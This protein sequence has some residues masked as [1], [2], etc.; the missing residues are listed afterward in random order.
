MTECPKCRKDKKSD[1][2]DKK[3]QKNKHDHH[4]EHSQIDHI[5][6]KDKK[7]IIKTNK[8]CDCKKCQ[9][10]KDSKAIKPHNEDKH[11]AKKTE[12]KNEVCKTNF[13]LAHSADKMAD[14]LP[15]VKNAN[16]SRSVDIDIDINP[17]VFTKQIENHNR[18]S[19]EIELDARATPNCRVVEK[20]V[21]DP[22]SCKTI[23][24]YVLL[25]EPDVELK[26]APKIRQ[27]GPKPYAKYEL[28]IVVETDTNATLSP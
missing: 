21:Y 22:S 24:K 10:K 27:I 28:D 14:F 15:S 7:K 6:Q 16:C 26:C 2:K 23:T 11:E 9:K 8:K 20:K 17:E 4:E 19:F 5:D 1:P 18:T 13:Y 3:N 25:V 12:H